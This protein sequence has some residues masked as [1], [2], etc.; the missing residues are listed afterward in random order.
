MATLTL[1]MRKLQAIVLAISSQL[2]KF[3]LIP[4]SIVKTTDQ[5]E[6]DKSRERIKVG[7]RKLQLQAQKIN[8]LSTELEKAIWELKAIATEV[9]ED[10]RFFRIKQRNADRFQICEYR[11]AYVPIIRQKSGGNLLLTS[12]TV[13]LSQKKVKNTFARY[14]S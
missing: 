6:T 10:S 9:N 7:L 11:S 5:A 1:I 12:R 3:A 4:S 13:D 14:D 8:Q 2:Q